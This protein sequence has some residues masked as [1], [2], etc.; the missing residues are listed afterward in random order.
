MGTQFALWFWAKVGDK[1][2]GDWR[3]GINTYAN[4]N[5]ETKYALKK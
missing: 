5:D 1:K 3:I 4:V 2:G